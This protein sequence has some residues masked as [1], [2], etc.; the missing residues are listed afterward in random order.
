MTIVETLRDMNWRTETGRLA[1]LVERAQD[2]IG[3]ASLHMDLLYVNPAGQRL[4]GLNNLDNAAK[5]ERADYFFPEDR[6]VI[7]RV[8]IP[9]VLQKGSWSGELRLRHFKTG[10][11]IPVDYNSLKI[12]DPQSGE[13]VRLGIVAH[14][15][16]Q[17]KYLEHQLERERDRLSLLLDLNNRMVSNLDLRQ[18]LRAIAASVRRAM[19]C[20]AVSVTLPAFEKNELRIFAVDFPEGK[21]FIKEERVLQME[22][23]IPGLV[24]R[25]AKPWCWRGETITPLVRRLRNS[26]TYFAIVFR[27]PPFLKRREAGI[28]SHR[29][30]KI[31]LTN[32]NPTKLAERKAVSE[33]GEPGSRGHLNVQVAC[34]PRPHGTSP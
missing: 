19:E 23:S 34:R 12:D 33:S 2:F 18:V 3:V 6:E 10:Q 32:P 27:I 22:Q 13:P 25:T 20:D 31:P 16:S 11:A 15:I 5:T 21:G 24:F 8:V 1:S 29:R 17:R 28:W 30:R 4:L 9:A 14:D 7:E 26:L